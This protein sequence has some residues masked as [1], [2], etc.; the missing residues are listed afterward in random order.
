MRCPDCEYRGDLGQA[1]DL[2]GGS[3]WKNQKWVFSGSESPFVTSDGRANV[4]DCETCKGT[5]EV[6][7]RSESDTLKFETEQKTLVT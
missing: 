4:E 5:G 2:L 6:P 3:V 1:P 7:W